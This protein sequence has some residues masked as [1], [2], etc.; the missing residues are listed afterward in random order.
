MPENIYM[1]MPLEQVKHDAC[2]GV[3]AARTAWRA[4]DPKSAATALGNVIEP[5]QLVLKH[6]RQEAGR[7]RQIVAVNP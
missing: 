2:V 4:R 3:F 7:T 6:E 5:G 1:R